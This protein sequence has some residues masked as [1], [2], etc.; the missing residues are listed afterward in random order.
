MSDDG[1]APVPE[2]M[3]AL[4]SIGSRRR[5]RHG[6]AEHERFFA[7]FLD[8]R[9]AAAQCTTPADV[10]DAFAA[11]ALVAAMDA[12]LGAFAAERFAARPPARRA[13]EAE[14]ADI[15]E[16]LRIALARLGERAELA[17]AERY[18]TE[19]WDGWLRQ[20]RATFE[21]ADALWP[22][23]DAALAPRTLA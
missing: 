4:R 6:I 10:I 15:V 7:P 3:S 5:T 14:L 9:R 19:A 1:F 12:V 21:I 13:F 22:L 23:L 16:P 17:A 20:L 2:L 11:S 18:T 8:A